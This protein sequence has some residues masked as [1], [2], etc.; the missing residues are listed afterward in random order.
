MT[1]VALSKTRSFLASAVIQA[2]RSQT[3]A[4]WKPSTYYPLGSQVESGGKIYTNINAGTSALTPP[5]HGSGISSIDGI[6]WLYLGMSVG[7]TDIASNLYLGI[8]KGTEW[9]D[10]DDVISP[11]N[12]PSQEIQALNDVEVLIRLTNNNTRI[13]LRKVPWQT[14]TVYSMFDPSVP[15]SS[16]GTTLPSMYVMVG[17]NIYKCLDNNGG[18]P[19]TD[20]P[21]G[22]Q[23]GPVLMSDGYIW[24]FMGTISTMDATDFGTTLYSPVVQKYSNDGSSQWDV[25]QA[26]KDGS[27]SAFTSFVKAGDTF[28]TTPTVNVVGS[29]TGASAGV[30]AN[31][32]GVDQFDLIRVYSTGGGQGYGP[33]TFAVV[34]ETG[35]IGSGASVDLILEDGKVSGFDNLVGGSS[36][37]EAVIVIIGDGTGAEATLTLAS[38]VVVDVNITSG[39][40]GYTWARAFIIPGTAGAVSQAI[41]APAGGH[42]R[43]LIAELNAN[44]LLISRSIDETLEPYVIDGLEFRQVLLVS[45]VQPAAGSS[46]NAEVYLGK[47]HPN[48]ETNPDGLNRAAIEGGHLLFVNNTE[49]TVYSSETE[50][51][52]KVA[53]TL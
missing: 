50:E 32:S 35:A 17:D 48:Y 10:G 18:V 6:Q 15:L 27:V 33:D 45:S 16:Y 24:K 14:G 46:P 25:Q 22:T 40:S 49:A 29:G 31:E 8:G 19:S 37:D 26:A 7:T 36:Y 38:G 11:Q 52:L 30:V 9:N 53:I 23:L 12:N 43:N 42:G 44:T 51:L 28:R 41:M 1:A 21:T 13:G 39:G 4:S 3:P 47:G 5:T 20:Q 34:Q 2:L